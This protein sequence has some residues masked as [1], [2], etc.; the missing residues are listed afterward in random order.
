MSWPPSWLSRCKAAGPTFS[1]RSSCRPAARFAMQRR[2]AHFRRSG[3]RFSGGPG[4]AQRFSA[5]R[6]TSRPTARFLRWPAHRCYCGQSQFLDALDGGYWQFGDDSTPPV[7][8]PISP[9]PRASPVG[10]GG[11]S[12]CAQTPQGEGPALQRELT[13][14]LRARGRSQRH[15]ASTQCAD[16]G[17]DV[18]LAVAC[19]LERRSA[20]R[21]LY[22]T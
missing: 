3:D 2:S 13:E 5:F 19:Y 20:F 10:I 14:K 16:R 9:A 8:S 6:P 11:S 22:S 1:P 17:Q 12:C 7:G 18:R 21:R 4:G 15:R